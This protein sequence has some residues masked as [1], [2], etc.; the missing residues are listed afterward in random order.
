MLK[1]KNMLALPRKRMLKRRSDFQ[2]VYHAGRAYAGH[3]LVLYVFRSQP[4]K[5]DLVGFAAG[6]KLGCAVVRNR[7]KR[8]LREAYRQNQ[9]GLSRGLTLLLVGRKPCVTAKSSCVAD[10]FVKLC[11]KAKLL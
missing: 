3:F 9:P 4:G 1:G 8:I 7:V 6:R 5:G 11:R 10:E 2:R